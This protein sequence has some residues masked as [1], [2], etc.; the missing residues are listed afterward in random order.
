ME[1]VI[2]LLW[3]EV[4]EPD[5]WAR[6]LHDRLAPQLDRLGAH[7]V[8]LNIQDRWV[9]DAPR[10]FVGSGDAPS[11]FVSVWLDSAN[12]DWRMPFDSAVNR[13]SPRFAAYSVTESEP[14]VRTEPAPA[15]ERTM[16]YVNVA[17]LRRPERIDRDNWFSEWLGRHSHVAI[18][19][20]DC[21]HYVQNV[22]ARKL[23]SS[24]PDWDAI[25]EEL[26]PDDAMGD[27]H[28][29][30]GA[31]GNDDLLEERI[32]EMSASVARFLDQQSMVVPTSEY[33]FTKLMR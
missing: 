20:Q 29:F 27:R 22:V 26:F 24:G 31:R 23:T 16:G 17:L 32:A 11:G 15:G 6:E 14:L 30:Y 21:R 18:A 28:A 4:S 5:T 9:A 33:V 19:I 1:K 10:R 13:V 8:Q 7:A 2:Y 3:P 25:V 12:P